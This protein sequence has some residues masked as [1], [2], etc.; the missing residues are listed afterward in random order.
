[1][2]VPD[3]YVLIK[4]FLAMFSITFESKGKID[5]FLQD[6]VTV[7]LRYRLQIHFRTYFGMCKIN[8][9]SIGWLIMIILQE[10]K[11][12]KLRQ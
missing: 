5:K 7:K 6:Y 4:W 1:M 10:N 11:I 2:I 9:E 12:E 8:L 3:N